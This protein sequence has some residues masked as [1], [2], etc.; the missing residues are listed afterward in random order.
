MTA[1][2]AGLDAALKRLA[3]ALDQLEAASG[4][5]TEVDA[6]RSDLREVLALMQDDRS[7][8]AGELDAA[9]ARAEALQLAAREIGRRLDGAGGVLRSLLAAPPGEV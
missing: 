6:D 5:L 7:R 8:L 3:A 9:T 4:R 1:W 2:P